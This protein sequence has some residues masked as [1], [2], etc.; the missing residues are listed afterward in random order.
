MF[1]NIFSSNE[2]LY[3]IQMANDG[4]TTGKIIVHHTMKIHAAMGLESL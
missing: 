2:T 1:M 3:M 4:L